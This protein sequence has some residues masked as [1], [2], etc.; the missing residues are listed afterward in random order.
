MLSF[1]K[2]NK[3]ETIDI[4]DLDE[5]IGKIE[6]IDV[7]EAYEYKTG[8][9]KTSKNIPMNELLAMPNKYIQTDKKYYIMC[10]SGMRSG[11]TAR[12]L[13]AL[14]FEV[15]NVRGGMGSYVGVKKNG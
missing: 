2:R 3:I 7:R 4:N 1:L 6:L 10:Q 12:A 5:L 13:S 9:I 15:V 8:G 11:R 14:G